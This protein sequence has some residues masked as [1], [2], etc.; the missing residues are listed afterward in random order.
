MEDGKDTTPE[1]EE[2]QK[3]PEERGQETLADIRKE[4]KPR[5]LHRKKKRGR[6]AMK[7]VASA[8]PK[9]DQEEKPGEGEAA[10]TACGVTV[11]ET[12]FTLGQAIGGDDWKPT[13]NERSYMVDAWSSYFR[14]KGITDLPPGWAVLIATAAYAVPRFRKPKTQARV[15][16]AYLKVRSWVRG[17][18]GKKEEAPPEDEK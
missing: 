1:G 9:S 5:R 16:A 10:S 3:A 18:M 6:P 8:A 2:K 17:L 4:A 11:A 12:I 14:A 7:K 15:I 13:E